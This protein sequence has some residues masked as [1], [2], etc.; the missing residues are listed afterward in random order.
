MFSRFQ[1]QS[2]VSFI[3]E[4]SVDVLFWLSVAV[5]YAVLVLGVRP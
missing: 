2:A 4:A 3:V 1:N 5:L